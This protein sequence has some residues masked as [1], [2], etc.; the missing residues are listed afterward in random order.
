[1]IVYL[2]V[3]GLLYFVQVVN[4]MCN[5]CGR[6][7]YVLYLHKFGPSF[8]N[9]EDLRKILS[10]MCKICARWY[11]SPQCARPSHYLCTQHHYSASHKFFMFTANREV[12]LQTIMKKK[13]NQMWFFLIIKKIWFLYAG[14]YC[15]LT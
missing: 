9:A 11:F 7:F 8:V 1:M 10:P 14:F 4:W 5:I 3:T 2:P 13:S 12:K 15:T 6:N